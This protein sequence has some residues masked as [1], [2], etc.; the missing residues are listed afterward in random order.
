MITLRSDDLLVRLDP[1][2]GGEILDLIDLRS[3]R[4]LLG[5]PPFGS[6]PILP[7]DLREER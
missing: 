6:E 1:D 7:G 5:R 3:G 4:Q 2:H